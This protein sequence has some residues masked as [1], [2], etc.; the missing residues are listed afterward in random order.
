MLLNLKWCLKGRLGAFHKRSTVNTEREREKKRKREGE[1]ERG[2]RNLLT[3][4][5]REKRKFESIFP[6][7]NADGPTMAAV[8]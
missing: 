5:Q 3:L 8:E 6:I 2:E 4:A 1:G 7:S